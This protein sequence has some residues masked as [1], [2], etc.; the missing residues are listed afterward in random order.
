[1]PYVL[2]LRAADVYNG[3][4]P[5]MRRD[6]SVVGCHAR[7]AGEAYDFV[8]LERVG[9]GVKRGRHDEGRGALRAVLKRQD[10][11][12]V[13]AS[14]KGRTTGHALSLELLW[15]TARGDGRSGAARVIE[16]QCAR[17]SARQAARGERNRLV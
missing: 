16:L 10:Q 14:Q 3:L 6:N 4:S 8:P 17:M 9:D 11:I 13:G 7:G 5:I 12:V 1:M 2:L 15:A